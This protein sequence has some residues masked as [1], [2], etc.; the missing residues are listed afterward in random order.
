MASNQTG[1]SSIL[2]GYSVIL[3]IVGD[4]VRVQVSEAK[5]GNGA[6]PCLEDLA[7]VAAVDGSLALAQVIGIKRD[8]GAPQAFG[9]TR[10]I[11]SDSTAHLL[12][13]PVQ[14]SYC[15]NSSGRR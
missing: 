10:G 2:V 14:A 12:G 6:A 13:H 15:H 5:S 11:S 1:I 8:V 9:G 7:V 4:I 3:G